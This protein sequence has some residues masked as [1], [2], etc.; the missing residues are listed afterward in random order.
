MGNNGMRFF[1]TKQCKNKRRRKK[2]GEKT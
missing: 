2:G 1:L